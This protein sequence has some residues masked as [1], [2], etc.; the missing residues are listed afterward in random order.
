[1]LTNEEKI[2]IVQQHMRNLLYNKYN[3]EI[4]LIEESAATQPNEQAIS[5][6]NND[7]SAINLKIAA[8]EEEKSLLEADING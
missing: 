8:L 3:L 6:I 1:M 2:G 5:V 4:S 7:L